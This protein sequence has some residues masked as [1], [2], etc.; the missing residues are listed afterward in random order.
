L[1]LAATASHDLLDD[2]L[3]QSH[4]RRVQEL[5][6]TLKS[7]PRGPV[8]LYPFEQGILVASGADYR[9]RPVFQS[10]MAYTPRLAHANADYLLDER[11]PASIL[12]RVESIDGRLP[13]LDD[14]PSWPIL[15]SHYEVAGTNGPFTVLQRSAARPWRLVPI[16]R[17][18]SRTGAAI[19]IPPAVDGPIWARIDVRETFSDK[20]LR[21]LLAAPIVR[22]DVAARFPWPR[23]FRIVPSLARDGFLLSPFVRHTADFVQLFERRT[24]AAWN[25]AAT[26]K[27][28]IDPVL[29]WNVGERAVTV[30]LFRLVVEPARALRPDDAG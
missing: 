14:A 17:I 27:L 23:N 20:L 8:D 5:R 6:E 10:Y 2:S 30:E 1:G 13:A 18:E 22:A 26:V 25:D 4:A 7:P 16:G 3:A 19:R 21:V 15:L 9:P 29:G 12:F 11:A 24:P 28:S